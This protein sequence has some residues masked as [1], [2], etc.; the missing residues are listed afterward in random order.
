MGI[1]CPSHVS[2]PELREACDYFLL[3]FSAQT[4]KCQNLRGLL[5]EL[6]NDGAE[7][8]FEDYL[9]RK[10]L[11]Q[12]VICATRG[13][14]EC[15]IVILMDEDRELI[16]WDDDFPPQMGEEYTQTIV[17]TSM[18]R[19]F[20]YVENRE[21]AKVVLRERGLKKV[22]LGIEGHPTH[23]EKVKKRPGGRAEVIY[24]YVQRPFIHMSW[25]KE[26]AK[27]R[28]VDF[29]CVKS[30]SVTNLAEAAADPNIDNFDARGNPI[31]PAAGVAAGIQ[32]SGGSA[33][34]LVGG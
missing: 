22:K 6:S 8:R 19:F 16:D 31:L 4:V 7:E 32:P 23:K 13:D 9:D 3:P 17:S 29:Q 2:I 30:K 11:P 25:E 18:C 21:V 15:H 24:N 14:R 12:M 28:H 1:H 34:V 5:H 33:G 26:E 20:R 27:S 10:I